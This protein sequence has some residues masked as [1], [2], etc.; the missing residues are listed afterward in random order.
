MHDPLD[1]NGAD[2][3]A[4]FG[5]IPDGTVAKINMTI[6]PGGAGPEGWLTASKSSDAQY[7]AAE[8]T[9]VEGEF[10]RR[11]FWGNLTVSG[12][13]LNEKGESK[14]GNI[15][16]STLRAMIESAFGINPKDESQQAQA[17]RR[18]PGY[19][20]LSGIEFAARIGVEP[21]KGDFKAKNKLDV[22]ITPD[23]PEWAQVM[24][25][26]ATQP[27]AQT[28]AQPSRTTMPSPAVAA[29]AGKPAG[30]MPAWLQR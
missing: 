8:F 14:G 27:A 5:L 19:G 4:D 28:M 13:Q 20:A 6:K 29:Q 17:A 11:K 30:A 1:L 21:A 18:L 26:A 9:I 15:T 24:R 2:P 25:R 12:G 16:R 3:Q 23:K 7:I 22:V 10:A